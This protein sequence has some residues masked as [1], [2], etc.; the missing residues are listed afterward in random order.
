MNVKATLI[1]I[2]FFS[3]KLFAQ[4][5]IV[6]DA[7]HKKWKNSKEYLIEVAEAMPA[8]K[9]SFKPVEGEMS[10]EEQLKHI[11]QNVS[12]LSTEKLLKANN[13]FT[14]DKIKAAKTKQEIINLVKEVFDYADQN[15]GLIKPEDFNQE[16]DF[17]VKN[18]N[19]LQILNLLQDHQ[20]HH[21]AQLLVYLRLNNIKPPS[22]RGW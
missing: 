5:S 3:I 7:W 22:Y 10:F 21:R 12:W 13:I 15:V 16:V 17:F 4:E 14:K 1:F 18:T 2:L 9:Y 19:K 11:V 6:L 8:E 20:T